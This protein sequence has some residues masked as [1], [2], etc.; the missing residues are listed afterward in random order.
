MAASS[1]KAA[2]ISRPECSCSWN[3]GAHGIHHFL[4]PL[5]YKST[6]IFSYRDIGAFPV[7]RLCLLFT[8]RMSWKKT[9]RDLEAVEWTRIRYQIPCLVPSAVS[10]VHVSFERNSQKTSLVIEG[11]SLLQFLILS[12]CGSFTKGGQSCPVV[13]VKPGVSTLEEARQ[14]DGD[15]QR[16]RMAA[17]EFASQ[18]GR[19]TRRS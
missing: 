11:G 6:P 16:P 4:D 17:K 2:F 10:H 15:K 1:R 7:T 5:S 9:P 13:R 8:F 3:G 14:T 19:G 18:K 12:Y